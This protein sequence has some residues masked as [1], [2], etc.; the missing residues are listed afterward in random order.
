MEE[1]ARSS[2]L[3]GQKSGR[4]AHAESAFEGSGAL[5][6]EIVAIKAIAIS[7]PVKISWNLRLFDIL[8]SFGR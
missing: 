7:A 5:T 3:R 6:A 2:S 8:V 4:S 1:G